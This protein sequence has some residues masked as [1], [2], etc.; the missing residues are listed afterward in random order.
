MTFQGTYG[1]FRDELYYIAC[2]KHLA[3]GYVDQPPLSLAIL[4]VWRAIF[5]DS[6]FALHFLPALTFSGTIILTSLIA[7]QIG[8]GR[9]AQWFAP[10]AVSSAHLLLGL[11][12]V[13][14][15]NAFDIFF[16]TLALY[17]VVK[18]LTDG[19]P[20]LWL[21]F[22]VVAGLGLQNKYSIGFLCIGLFFGLLF[23]QHRKHLKT[24]WFWLGASLAF[25]I[26]LPH[27]LWEVMN[28]FPSL[29]FMRNASQYKNIGLTPLGLFSNNAFEMNVLNAPIWTLGLYFFFFHT[30]GKKFR[31]IGWIYITVFSILIIGSGKAYYLAPI[32]PIL[33]AGG[34]VLVEQ[35]VNRPWWRW[36]IPIHIV[37][38]VIVALI[39]SPFAIPVLPVE[40]FIRYQSFLGMKPQ[41]SERQTLSALPQQ[42]A[43]RFGWEEMT[44]TVAG[45][46]QKLPPEDQTKCVIFMRN[47]GEA[48][49]I[50]FFGKKYNLPSAVCAHNS[51]W[52]WGCGDR[53]GDVAIILGNSRNLEE[54][55][56]DLTRG[57]EHVELA[58]ITNCPLAMPYENGRQI[59]LCRGFRL[60]FQ[61]IWPRERFA[62]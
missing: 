25:L 29:E 12:S 7:R 8:G 39:A 31:V 6:L 57:F 41:T 11:T 46:Y 10:L 20:K 17:I 13:Y 24:K 38:I 52:Y 16:W 40:T 47:Y 36:L 44:A 50:D 48:G 45:V 26:F 59:F 34:A 28:G 19:S 49:A 37:E 4:T 18:I 35:F 60:S 2:S 61:E 27:I 23:T 54:N 1:Y 5:G 51:Y 14:S 53:K 55:M 62:I 30:Q 58:A 42:Y 33:L 9:F 43:D 15:M 3:F 22:G 32:Y 21:L 56:K